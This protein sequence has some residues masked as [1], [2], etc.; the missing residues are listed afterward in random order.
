MIE[1]LIAQAMLA[2]LSELDSGRFTWAWQQIH[3][4]AL[5]SHPHFWTIPGSLNEL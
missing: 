3:H 2:G 1:V 4:P 5:Q